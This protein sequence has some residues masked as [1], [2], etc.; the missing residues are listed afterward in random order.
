MKNDAENEDETHSNEVGGDGGV[1][2]QQV[3]EC[4][5]SIISTATKNTT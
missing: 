1:K 3:M 4:L 2:N 5:M